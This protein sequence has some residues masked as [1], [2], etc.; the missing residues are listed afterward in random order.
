[1][2]WYEFAELYHKYK[3]A[4]TTNYVESLNSVRRK[5]ADKRLNFS[6]TYKCRANISLLSSFLD[7]WVELLFQELQIT[8]SEPMLNY[9]K[10][11]FVYLSVYQLIVLDAACRFKQ[12]K[13][14]KKDSQVH[15]TKIPTK[16][17][18]ILQEQ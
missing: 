16:R 15:L 6:A 2:V 1:M 5:F 18:Q 7:N 3:V 9:L 14:E 10:V 4:D 17:R 12:T 8:I 11:K 13:T